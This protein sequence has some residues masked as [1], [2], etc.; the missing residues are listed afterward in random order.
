MKQ[1]ITLLVN[2]ESH[3][4]IIEPR[5]TLLEVL[6]EQ[7]GLTGAKE[8]C[9]TGDCGACTVLMEG[10]AVLACLVLAVRAQGKEIE[11]IEGISDGGELHP[12]Q[13]AFIAKGAVQCGYC[14][15]GMILSAKAFLE[16]VP[17]PSL[18]MVQKALEGNLCRCTGYNEIIE[19]VLEAGDALEKEKS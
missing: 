19:A 1:M 18:F 6:R 3:E 4:V 16:K 8:S 12:L 14:T 5:T 17:K 7:L 15:P 9:N 2:G 13:R 11:T 10:H